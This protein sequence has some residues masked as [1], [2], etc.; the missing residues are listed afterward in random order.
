MDFLTSQ[1]I[2]KNWTESEQVIVERILSDPE[3]I[4]TSSIQELAR[5]CFVSTSS[6][7]RLLAKIELDEFSSLKNEIAKSLLHQEK[8][9]KKS[10]RTFHFSVCRPT[11]KSLNNS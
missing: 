2:N 9:K 10:T 6:I 8:K 11:M 1:K 3:S 7:Y 4:L 5:S